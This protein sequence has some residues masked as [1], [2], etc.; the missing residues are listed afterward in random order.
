MKCYSSGKTT[1]RLLTFLLQLG[2]ISG[3]SGNST[4]LC[5]QHEKGYYVI[6]KT[7]SHCRFT[8]NLLFVL[9]YGGTVCM[10]Q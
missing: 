1:S 8:E 9:I 2:I 10:P 4:V 5:K 3:P 6:N 7:C